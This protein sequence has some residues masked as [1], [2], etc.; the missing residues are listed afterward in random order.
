MVSIEN[1]LWTPNTSS[2]PEGR[3]AGS[4]WTIEHLLPQEWKKNWPLEKTGDPDVR[5]AMER[6]RNLSVHALGNLTLLT[7]KL[8]SSTSNRSWE[9]KRDDISKQSL[10]LL[11]TQTVLN[12]PDGVSISNGDWHATWSELHIDARTK[13]L[14]EFAIK[15]WPRP[16]E[17]ESS[18]AN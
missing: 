18:T 9:K 2:A 1:A 14:S 8:N 3:A 10:L 17:Q 6:K 5:D 12:K 7:T 15:M 13:W 4:S 16:V 11:T